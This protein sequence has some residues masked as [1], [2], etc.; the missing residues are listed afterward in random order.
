MSVSHGGWQRASEAAQ[1][2]AEEVSSEPQRLGQLP[3][4]SGPRLDGDGSSAPHLGDCGG[5]T[6]RT[7]HSLVCGKHS[8][9]VTTALW[10]H[11]P[12][13]HPA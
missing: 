1:R 2:R 13:S 11:D 6:S 5:G 4:L 9:I 3:T 10:S 7:L 12:N 8:V